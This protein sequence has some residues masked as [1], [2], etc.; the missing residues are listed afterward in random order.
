ME[1]GRV[2]LSGLLIF[3]SSAS[4]AWAEDGTVREHQVKAAFTYNFIKLATWPPASLPDGRESIIQCILGD[5]SFRSALQ[6]M[7]GKPAHG[8]AVTVVPIGGPEEIGRCHALVVGPSERDRYPRIFAE[9]RTHH[10]LTVSAD[11]GFAG[12]GGIIELILADQNKVRFIIDMEAARASG[13]QLSSRLLKLAHALR[14]GS[15]AG[16]R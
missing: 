11:A 5:V 12:Q 1:K 9:S 13:I 14:G 8:R 3:L 4:A 16:G 7:E 6:A 10:V 15:S 2:L